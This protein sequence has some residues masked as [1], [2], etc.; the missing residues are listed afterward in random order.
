MVSSPYGA[1]ERVFEGAI[2]L[3]T[4]V[5]PARLSEALS[6][7]YYTLADH[8]RWRSGPQIMETC[9]HSVGVAS[10]CC[11]NWLV[12]SLALRPSTVHM[13]YVG[14]PCWVRNPFGVVQSQTYLTVAAQEACGVPLVPHQ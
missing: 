14:V 13:Y 5:W 4:T 9:L 10:G 2:G 8:I 1:Q 7:I 3:I 6:H 12:S 11:A